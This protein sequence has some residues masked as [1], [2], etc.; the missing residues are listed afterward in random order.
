MTATIFTHLLLT[1]TLSLKPYLITNHCNFL[2]LSKKVKEMIGLEQLGEMLGL[3][4]SA[5]GLTG[6]A[7][8]TAEKI[9]SLLAKKDAVDSS[10]LMGLLNT[11]ATQLTSVNMTNVQLS[12]A[13]KGLSREL[14]RQDEFEKLKANYV[15]FETPEKDIVYRLKDEEVDQQ[16]AHFVCPVC[17]GRDKLISYIVGEDD[18]KRCQT[19]KNHTF[20]FRNTPVKRNLQGLF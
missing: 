1:H 7:T 5:V 14:Q 9:Q 20:R 3:A 15:L 8:E 17:L 2:R 11:L 19:D 13:V 4:S 16:P 10:E 6:K 18:F 12:E